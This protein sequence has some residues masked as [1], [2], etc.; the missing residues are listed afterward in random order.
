MKHRQFSFIIIPLAG[1]LIAGCLGDNDCTK[2]E[3]CAMEP[4]PGPCMAA[5]PRYYYDDKAGNCKEF[6]WGGCSEFPFETF[7]ECVTECTCE[8]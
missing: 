1:S 5:F 6:T 7:E 4:E 8:E 2:S 3:K